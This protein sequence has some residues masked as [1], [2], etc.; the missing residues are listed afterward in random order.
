[1]LG[2]SAHSGQCFGLFNKGHIT[3]KKRL[4]IKNQHY[5]EIIEM[6]KVRLIHGRLTL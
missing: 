1:L 2:T 3:F 5:F 6:N 4:L